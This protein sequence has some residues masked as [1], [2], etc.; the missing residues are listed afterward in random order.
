MSNTGPIDEKL[1]FSAKHN[2]STSMNCELY[3]TSYGYFWTSGK[4]NW[5]TVWV[6][7]VEYHSDT[8]TI[9]ARGASFVNQVLESICTNLIDEWRNETLP[10]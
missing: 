4:S 6:F 9:N 8:S 1:V 3:L 5:R 2:L 7:I 10:V